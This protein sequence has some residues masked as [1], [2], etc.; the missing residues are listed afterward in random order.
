[1]AASLPSLHV[2]DCPSTPNPHPGCR[3]E[4]SC[5]FS[6]CATGI[7]APMYCSMWELPTTATTL[8]GFS[9][10]SVWRQN[11]WAFLFALLY[12]PSQACGRPTHWSFMDAG[13][14]GASGSPANA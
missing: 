10:F 13:S 2:L 4:I 1:M 11:P 12:S 6:S 3:T 7:T 14:T 5:Q 9:T 8:V